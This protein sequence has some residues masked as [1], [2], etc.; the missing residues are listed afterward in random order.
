MGWIR[1]VP[2]EGYC[3]RLYKDDVSS[4]PSS[5]DTSWSN[6]LSVFAQG[7]SSDSGGGTSISQGYANQGTSAAISNPLASFGSTFGGGSSGAPTSDNTYS[8]FNTVANPS[9]ASNDA[10]FTS[11]TTPFQTFGQPT[12]GASAGGTSAVAAPPGVNPSSFSVDPTSSAFTQGN[13]LTP[14]QLGQPSGTPAP[15]ANQTGGQQAQQS[16]GFF[17]NLISG[18]TGSVTKNPLGAVGAL[19]AGGGLINN[20]IQGQK[21]DPAA[22]QLQALANQLGPQASQLQSYL[23]NGT[24]PPGMQ[25][26]VDQATAAAKARVISSYASRGQ[27]TDPSQNSALAQELSSIDQNA[28]VSAGQLAV[29]LYQQGVSETQIN[30]QIY[31]AL[32]NADQAQAKQTQDAL[33]SFASALGRI[34][35]TGTTSKTS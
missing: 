27:S 19:A 22:Q 30:A 31:N 10:A 11:G 32:L 2:D 8:T 18:L 20:L 9:G 28:V 13:N 23:A 21:Q 6:P 26:S 24:L 4:G 15:Q 7:P 17:D 16:G 35:S 12:S 3:R 29:Q 33:G 34:G 25:A 14:Q 1:Y 5:N